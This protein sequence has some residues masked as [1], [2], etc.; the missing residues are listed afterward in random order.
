MGTTDI[1]VY[2]EQDIEKTIAN[3]LSEL[4]IKDD[5]IC[6]LNSLL[7]QYDC[8]DKHKL[9]NDIESLSVEY[10]YRNSTDAFVFINNVIDDYF[11]TENCSEEQLAKLK[12]SLR[13]IFYDGLKVHFSKI[14]SCL[15]S[16][17]L[18]ANNQLHFN[19]LKLEYIRS[20]HSDYLNYLIESGTVE[21]DTRQL[22]YRLY[23]YLPYDIRQQV[24][25]CLVHQNIRY[26]DF[27]KHGKKSLKNKVNYDE[28]SFSKLFRKTVLDNSPGIIE[29]Y[30]LSYSTRKIQKMLTDHCIKNNIIPQTIKRKNRKRNA[31]NELIDV[32][33]LL[34]VSV[35]K[36][37]IND[38]EN[39]S[40]LVVE[41]PY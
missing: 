31:K 16:L 18:T 37:I 4:E 28:K 21:N 20:K 8:N 13:S 19:E 30:K 6:F 15:E 39:Q 25:E 22:L 33:S 12:K 11:I 36:Q 32:P 10:S 41:G 17:K 5:D 23:S 29:L 27:F 9:I 1:A 35:I 3:V 26:K 7:N 24:G 14:K 40:P 34:P 2:S 38:Y